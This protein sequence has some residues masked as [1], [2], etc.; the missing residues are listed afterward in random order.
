MGTRLRDALEGARS[1]FERPPGT[2]WRESPIVA[3]VVRWWRVVLVGLICLVLVGS[4]GFALGRARVTDSEAARQ[5]GITAGEQRGT[6]LGRRE[7]YDKTFKPSRERAYRSAYRVAYREA[8]RK[9]FEK[10]DLTVPT[11]IEVKGP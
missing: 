3:R 11:N 8:Y 5:A 4:I 1:R 7:G 9:S 2:D 6:A 10:A